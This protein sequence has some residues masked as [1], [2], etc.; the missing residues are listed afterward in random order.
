MLD[1]TRD[2]G[3]QPHGVKPEVRLTARA[4]AKE[5]PRQRPAAQHTGV[6]LRQRDEP[7]ARGLEP[8]RL[9]RRIRPPAVRIPPREEKLTQLALWISHGSAATRRCGPP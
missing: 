7:P 2:E 3:E 1:A 4:L 8:G 5:I 9:A 6:G